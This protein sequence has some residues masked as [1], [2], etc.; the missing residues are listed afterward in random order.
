M[1]NLYSI[2]VKEAIANLVSREYVGARLAIF[3]FTIAT[4]APSVTLKQ[5]LA[6]YKRFLK[7]CNWFFRDR[8]YN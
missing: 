2:F 3:Y 1:K 8:I 4:W 6:S 7:G 5:I